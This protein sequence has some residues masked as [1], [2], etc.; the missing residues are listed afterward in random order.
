MTYTTQTDLEDAFGA[1]ELVQIADR[2]GD[3]LPDAG[4]LA[5]VS[6]RAYSFING[7]LAG[8]YALPLDAP[9]PP[10]IIAASC[11]LERYWL[12]DDDATERVREGFE[13]VVAWLKDVD[14]GKVLLQLPGASSNIAMGSPDG[15]APD[16]MF[17]LSGETVL[18]QF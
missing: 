7:Y 2:D 1:T 13:D 11:D 4:L 18:S 16:R 14:A 8:R 3:G 9:Y 10:V 5:A 15:S 6:K 12:Y 17:D